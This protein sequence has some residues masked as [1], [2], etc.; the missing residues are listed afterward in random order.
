M[1]AAGIGAPF[2]IGAWGFAHGLRNF[3]QFLS[4]M[5][6]GSFFIA[7]AP[8]AIA[9]IAIAVAAPP[10]VSSSKNHYSQ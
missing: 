3:G 8:L 5:D 7:N 6:F 9:L 4:E 1:V 2:V 10:L